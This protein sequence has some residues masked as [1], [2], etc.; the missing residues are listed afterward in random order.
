MYVCIYIYVCIYLYICI[1]MYIYIC[2]YIYIY[3][4]LSIYPSIYPSIYLSIYLYMY[5]YMCIYYK[6]LYIYIYSIL[7]Y[8]YIYRQKVTIFGGRGSPSTMGLP[9]RSTLHVEDLWNSSLGTDFVVGKW[10]KNGGKTDVKWKKHW[11]KMEKL[12]LRIWKW[13]WNGKVF[14][15]TGGKLQEWME[16]DGKKKRITATLD[17][18]LVNVVLSVSSQCPRL[19][20]CGICKF[21]RKMAACPL[22]LQFKSSFSSFSAL[23]FGSKPKAIGI[24]SEIMHPN[25]HL[26]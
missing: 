18:I 20:K 11:K 15:Q 6:I 26:L 24:A 23:L 13:R 21:F 2:I 19:T 7:Y 10:C 1:C 14:I 12:G 9:P 8:I 17:E 25:N 4:Y 16:T 5:L 3:I 22:H